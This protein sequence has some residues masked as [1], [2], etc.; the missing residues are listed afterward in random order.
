MRT[1]SFSRIESKLIPLQSSQSMTS[2]LLNS[3]TRI[4]YIHSF[5]TTS[6]TNIVL[7]SRIQVLTQDLTQVFG[8]SAEIL[9]FPR[10][11]SFFS[12]FDTEI[13]SVYIGG[14]VLISRIG[15]GVSG[16]SEGFIVSGWFK[17]LCKW[18]A[19]TSSISFSSV[20]FLAFSSLAGPSVFHHLPIISLVILLTVLESPFLL[21]SLLLLTCSIKII[22]S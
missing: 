18:L 14:S 17:T 9:S 10:T 7:E 19:Q 16:I 2:L 5:G 20:T 11:L 3:F 15:R 6:V 1:R 13:I 21:P 12:F 8:I 4:L 22:F